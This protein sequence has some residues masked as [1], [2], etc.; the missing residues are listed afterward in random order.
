MSGNITAKPV[1]KNGKTHF[2][3]DGQT[4]K[5]DVETIKFH[6]DDL[7]SGN[8]LLTENLNKVIDENAN[9]LAEDVKPVIAET[10]STLFLRYING[11][12]DRFPIDV[13]Y[14]KN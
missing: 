5:V 14:P 13:L 2:K 1:E 6:L 9:V 3:A 7:F 12:N 10:L 11:V 4:T 8:P